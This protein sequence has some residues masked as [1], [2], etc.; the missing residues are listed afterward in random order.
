M[1]GEQFLFSAEL[2]CPEVQAT[3]PKPYSIRPLRR[4]DYSSGYLET[5]SVLTE[6]GE[7]SR[8]QFEERFDEMVRRKDTYYIVVIE[9]TTSKKVVATGTVVVELKFINGIS[10]AA[11]LEDVAVAE[12]CQKMGF[13]L[14][15]HR[16]R[17]F[18]VRQTSCYKG[19]LDCREYNVGFH[20][21][22]GYKRCGVYMKKRYDGVPVEAFLPA[23]S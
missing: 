12:E 1:S 23:S 17:D 11:H 6:V 21:K 15:I 9:D 20:E 22:A 2:I 5:L 18:I 3:L 8:K 19:V 10:K 13:G 14:Q 4:S 7:I 16:A